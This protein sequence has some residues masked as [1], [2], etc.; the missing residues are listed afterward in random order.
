MA[1][2]RWIESY[3]YTYWCVQLDDVVETCDNARFCI[4]DVATFSAKELRED[5]ESCLAKAREACVDESIQPLDSEYDDLRSYMK[6]F[7]EE[8]DTKYSKGAI[9]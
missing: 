6:E 3:W 4:C 5:I 2:S 9:P 1:Y 7:L 8:V